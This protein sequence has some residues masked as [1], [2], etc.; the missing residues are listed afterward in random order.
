MHILF[1]TRCLPYPYGTGVQQRSYRHLKA[2]ATIGTVDTVVLSEDEHDAPEFYAPAKALSRSL[3]TGPTSKVFEQEKQRYLC[4]RS[5][6]RRLRLLMTT[7]QPSTVRP[8]GASEAAEAA[9]V[10][11]GNDYDLAFCFRI[12]SAT[13]LHAVERVA[14]LRYRGIVVDFDDIESHWYRHLMEKEWM[15][16]SL[17]WRLHRMRDVLLMRSV[18]NRLLRLGWPV[19]CC[20]DTDARALRSRVPTAPVS[21]IPNSVEVPAQPPQQAKHEGF[22]VLFVGALNYEPNRDGLKF[23]VGRVWPHVRRELGGLARLHIVGRHPMADVLALDGRDGI[24]VIGPAPVMAPEY[25]RA[26]ICVAPI[27]FGSGTRIKI[28]E[29]FAQFRPVVSTSQGAAGIDATDGE[30]IIIADRA[31]QFAEAIV[32]LQRDPARRN[33][34]AAAAYRFVCEHYEEGVVAGRL[35][36]IAL[37][38]SNTGRTGAL[39]R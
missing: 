22:V 17:A 14:N 20:S 28:L 21:I 15:K 7:M 13:W 8:I 34:I 30:E 1:L 3:T 16:S 23:F 10:V 12:S 35:Q 33:R 31:D 9:K 5:A 4:E 25:A 24:D 11:P 39:A 18:E 19:L 38:A 27:R 32:E 2:L 29:S 26:D 36:A 37:H 6:I